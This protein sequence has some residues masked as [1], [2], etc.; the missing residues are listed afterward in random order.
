MATSQLSLYNG[1]LLALKERK[2]SSLVENNEARRTLDQV[3]DG[4]VKYCLEAGLWN[5]AVRTAKFTYDPS[6]VPAFGYKYKFV[7]PTDFV[8]LNALCHDEFFNTPLNAY[9]DEAGAWYADVDTLYVSYVSDAANYGNNMAGW[10]ESF[11][12]F[13]ELYLADQAGG[14]ITGKE[15]T[16]EKLLKAAEKEARAKDAMNEP[17]KFMPQGRWTQARAGG[18]IRRDR[19][20]RGSL[21]G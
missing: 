5:F 7:K 15:G 21:I 6:F 4:A 14:R 3:W 12:N 13:V 9:T 8:R 11:V 18:N 19:G 20:N 1:A 10:P 2:L 17:T 16:V